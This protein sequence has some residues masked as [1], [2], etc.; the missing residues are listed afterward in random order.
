M[1]SLFRGIP[2][3]WRGRGE[4]PAKTS[5]A[6]FNFNCKMFIPMGI[7][8]VTGEKM[9]KLF[10]ILFTGLLFTIASAETMRYN[11]S[12]EGSPSAGP[13]KAPVTIV[14]FIDYQ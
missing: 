4:P 3:P 12:L 2:L 9:N 14:E 7:I 11:V 6:T 13:Q 8:K 1:S 5:S 10:I